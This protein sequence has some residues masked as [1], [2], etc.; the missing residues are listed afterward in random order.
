MKVIECSIFPT[1]KE[2]NADQMVKPIKQAIVNAF[3]FR[4]IGNVAED[5]ITSIRREIC[6]DLSSYFR[7]YRL[8]EIL[9]AIELGAKGQLEQEGDMNTVSVELILKWI[10]RFN[11]KIRKEANHKQFQHEKKLD[12][13]KTEEERLAGV[14]W[15]ENEVVRVYEG[16]C[17]GSIDLI[18]ISDELKESYFR[19]MESKGLINE[20]IISTQDSDM[21]W[22]ISEGKLLEIESLEREERIGLRPQLKISA[23][24]K[25]RLQRCTRIAESLAFTHICGVMKSREVNIKQLFKR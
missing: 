4:G 23:N 21:I 9:L 15:A 14:M 24:H 19:V 2:L 13:I 1:I 12:Q 3:A 6:K 8:N 17:D 22:E 5:Q 7:T 20:S 16:F 18:G 25:T 11:E 10:N